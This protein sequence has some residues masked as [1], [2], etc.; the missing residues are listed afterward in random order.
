MAPM[1]LHPLRRGA[2]RKV[3]MKRVI[4]LSMVFCALVLSACGPQPSTQPDTLLQPTMLQSLTARYQFFTFEMCQ[5]GG[6]DG[7][8]SL[9]AEGTVLAGE[10]AET[11]YSSLGGECSI[12]DFDY[13]A[14]ILFDVDSLGSQTIRQATLSFRLVSG[15]TDQAQ[16]Q[17]SC[18]TELTVSDA[19][20]K[21]YD[22]TGSDLNVPAYELPLA[23]FASAPQPTPTAGVQLDVAHAT[24]KVDVTEAVKGWLSKRWPNQG[25]ILRKNVGGMASCLSRY[26]DF[27]LTIAH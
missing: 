16:G 5:D 1:W 22:V 26:T 23:D 18:A 6:P 7:F 14:G 21:D 3:A 17:V 13:Y 15:E 12:I 20:W 25:L 2:E 10:Q 19:A 27:A 24:L 9:P 11:S 8:E 4:I